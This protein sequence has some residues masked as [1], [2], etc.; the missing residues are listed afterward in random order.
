MECD[1]LQMKPGR[2]LDYWRVDGDPPFYLVT[3]R[4]LSGG[5]KLDEISSFIWLHIDGTNTVDSIITEICNSFEGAERKQVEQDVIEILNRFEAD[6]LIILDYNPL[7]PYKGLKTLKN[8]GK[9]QFSK[10]KYRSEDKKQKNDILF[11]TPPSALVISR[12]LGQRLG[13]VSPLGIGYLASYLQHKG[14]RA[15]CLNLYL[16]IK[17]LKSLEHH[18][19][20]TKPTIIGF[21]TMTETHQNG[22][23]L[24]EFVKKVY[25]DAIIVFGGPHV[26]FM[27]E[28][29]LSNDC[30][31][32]VVRREG[33]ETMLELADYFV[34]KRGSLDDIKGIVYKA[35][36]KIVRTAARPMMQDLDKLP[37]PTR[38]I[39]DLDGILDPRFSST[40]V[41]T[42]RGCPGRCKF[43]A[44][45][46]L[47]GGKFRLRSVDNVVAEVTELKRQGAKVIFLADD[48]VSSDIPRLLILCQALKD[49]GIEWGAECRIDAMT[50]DLAK[51]LADS[52]CR[53]LQFGVESGSQEL[54]DKMRKDITLKQ[55]EHAVKCTTEAGLAVM[56]S[57]MLGLP[58]DTLETM[59]QTI[60]FADR[61]QREFKT[62][63]ALGCTLPYPGTYYYNHAKELGL[64]ISTY[65]YNL[66]ST[67]SPIMDTPNLTRWQIRNAYNNSTPR[68]Y[69]SL[70]DHFKSA[71]SQ[72]AKASL[73]KEGYEVDFDRLMQDDEYQ[74]E[75]EHTNCNP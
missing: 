20:Q 40:C 67:I 70:P 75:S 58:E 39:P 38:D 72:F 14:F 31:D 13:G 73:A 49:I 12:M 62:G 34:R 10:R 7:Y 74:Q 56:C 42:S 9:N 33:E 46:A 44:A 4:G 64:K 57:L 68:L 41:I 23:L 65:N 45:A 51:T 54:L 11:I 25:P 35:N 63:T 36:G 3:V 59:Q 21:S 48:T 8:I 66:W 19:K 47:S 22:L 61:L 29:T 5:Y 69:K 53:S 52:G 17:D 37:F 1:M 50:R 15:D 28:E 30:V 71:Y 26:T 32:I 2:Y 43:C 24:A 60:D 55:V 6:D 18:I 27:Y 16:G